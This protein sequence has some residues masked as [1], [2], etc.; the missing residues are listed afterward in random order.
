[1]W[2]RDIFVITCIYDRLEL[3]RKLAKSSVLTTTYVLLPWSHIK[4]VGIVCKFCHF[5]D[6]FKYTSL[7][8]DYMTIKSIYPINRLKNTQ[9]NTS[10]KSKWAMKKHAGQMAVSTEII[11]TT[12]RQVVMSGWLL[13]AV[14]IS[15]TRRHVNITV[16]AVITDGSDNITDTTTCNHIRLLVRVPPPLCRHL[17]IGSLNHNWVPDMTG[18]LCKQLGLCAKYGCMC[19]YAPRELRC[20][21]VWNRSKSR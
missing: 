6:V 5:C 12:S 14:T 11:K 17:G 16:S 21:L 2:C 15:P 10:S 8:Q 20:V 4:L 19:C 13:T 1:M 18:W 3:F 7:S 9:E